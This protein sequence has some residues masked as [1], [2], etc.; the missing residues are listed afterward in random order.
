MCGMR[1][2]SGRDA[3]AQAPRQAVVSVPTISVCHSL[4][5]AGLG[6]GPLSTLA[7]WMRTLRP[8]MV[9]V[10]S[11]L[12][13]DCVKVISAPAA[14]PWPSAVLCGSEGL[15]WSCGGQVLKPWVLSS[16]GVGV[17]RGE[18]G[19]LGLCLGPPQSSRGYSQ[20]C[21]HTGLWDKGAP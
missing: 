19:A 5:T 1:A 13:R 20:C 7:L 11:Q 12:R 15:S 17:C 14:C 21:P 6:A 16:V 10:L 9:I 4:C 3:C 18:H 2:V 8:G